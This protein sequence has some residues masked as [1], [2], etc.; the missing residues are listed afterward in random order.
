MKDPKEKAKELVDKMKL[1]LFS[2]GD[3]DAKQ[4]AL[5]AVDEILNLG[6]LMTQLNLEKANKIVPN[7]SQKEY[8]KK[9]KKEIKKL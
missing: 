6:I 3:Y 7:N 2:D 9:V 5:I 8:W 1:F 4:C